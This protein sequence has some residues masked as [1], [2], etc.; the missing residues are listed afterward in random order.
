M[1]SIVIALHEDCTILTLC[2]GPMLTLREVGVS[3]GLDLWIVVVLP[4]CEMQPECAT[5]CPRVGPASATPALSDSAAG[6]ILRL[7]RLPCRR[8][9]SAM[10]TQ[11]WEVTLQSSR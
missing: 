4:E 2:C 5:I 7:D 11:A 1:R 9:F 8:E 10:K 6:N 3:V